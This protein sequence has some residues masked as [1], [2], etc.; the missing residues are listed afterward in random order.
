MIATCFLKPWTES[1]SGKVLYAV[2]TRPRRAGTRY[3]GA[4]AP[5]RAARADPPPPGGGRDAIVPVTRERG[6]CKN[7]R[8]IQQEMRNLADFAHVSRGTAAA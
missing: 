1:D 8:E 4:A 2:A 3:R 6:D 7:R 5:I